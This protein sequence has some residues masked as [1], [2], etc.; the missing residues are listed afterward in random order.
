M[1]SGEENARRLREL[2]V[3]DNCIH[4]NGGDYSKS[5][6]WYCDQCPLSDLGD[7]E[8]V[9]RQFSKLLCPLVRSYSK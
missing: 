9:T 4:R 5:G 2:V 1:I 7:G 6:F 3:G 8:R